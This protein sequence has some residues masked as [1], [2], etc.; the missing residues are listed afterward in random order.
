MGGGGVLGNIL[1]GALKQGAAQGL[2]GGIMGALT[3]EGFGKG[4]KQGAMMGAVAG[5]VG[6]LF[7]PITTAGVSPAVAQPASATSSAAAA[8]AP[9][10]PTGYGT[11]VWSRSMGGTGGLGAAV[12]PTGAAPVSASATTPTGQ[13][14][15]FGGGFG[16]FLQSQGGAGLIAGIGAG[17]GSYYETEAIKEQRE[18]DR[19]FVRDQEQRITD[20]YTVPTTALAGGVPAWQYNP[21]TG[22]IELTRAG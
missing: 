18:A 9:A 13:G 17:L 15:L 4:L 16:Q 3:G 5:G 20:S 6:G 14:G 8:A 21:N 10:T 22:Q 7:D 11:D 1:S 19:Q 12:T 2:V